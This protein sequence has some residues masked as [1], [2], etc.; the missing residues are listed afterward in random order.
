MLGTIT[1]TG[2]MHLKSLTCYSWGAL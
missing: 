1:L 2:K